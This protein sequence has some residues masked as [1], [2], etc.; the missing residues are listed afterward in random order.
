[1]R[2]RG[3]LFLNCQLLLEIKNSLHISVL[4]TVAHKQLFAFKALVCPFSSF[5][6]QKFSSFRIELFI[7]HFRNFGFPLIT[8]SIIAREVRCITFWESAKVDP[9]SCF[10]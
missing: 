7:F 6:S 1:M 3:L 9:K 4:V 8:D 5:Y 10:F 2:L